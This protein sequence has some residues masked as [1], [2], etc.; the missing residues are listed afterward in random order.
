[1]EK[2]EVTKRSLWRSGENANEKI[3]KGNTEGMSLQPSPNV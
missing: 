2:E 1:M 3:V